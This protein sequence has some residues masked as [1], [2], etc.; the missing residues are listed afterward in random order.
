[1]EQGSNAAFTSL[2]SLAEG[3]WELPK[4]LGGVWP[5]DHVGTYCNMNNKDPACATVL[6]QKR[7]LGQNSPTH[8]GHYRCNGNPAGLCCWDVKP[9]TLKC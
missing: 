5:G 1:M 9:P 7:Q 2:C 6:G 3:F 8:Q 4:C